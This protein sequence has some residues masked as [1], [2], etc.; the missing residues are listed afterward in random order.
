MRLLACVLFLAVSAYLV[1][2]TV[3]Q[4][5]TLDPCKGY[6]PVYIFPSDASLNDS[7]KNFGFSYAWINEYN[8]PPLCFQLTNVQ[9]KRVQILV[10]TI[11]SD[12]GICVKDNGNHINNQGSGAIDSCGTGTLHSCFNTLSNQ[13]TMN[14]YIYCGSNCPTSGFAL[15]FRAVLS[16]YTWNDAASTSNSAM[17]SL[18][19]WCMNEVASVHYQFPSNINAETTTLTVKD[20]YTPG[21]G[22]PQSTDASAGVAIVPTPITA[23]LFAALFAA[24]NLL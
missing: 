12:V 3:G 15:N 6:Y 23:F 14:V 8:N 22:S 21:Q 1:S 5:A 17:N 4:S 20:V 19:M 13:N 24:I 9:N 16:I 18:D 7:K 10:E 11:S 2:S